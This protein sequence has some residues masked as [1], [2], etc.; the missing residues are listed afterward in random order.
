M[1]CCSIK[2]TAIHHK[3]A[4]TP[5]AITVSSRC[6]MY[7]PVFSCLRFFASTTWYTLRTP[8]H[9]PRKS[10]VWKQSTSQA[11]CPIGEQ[12]SRLRGT[13]RPCTIKSGLWAIGCQFSVL[14]ERQPSAVRLHPKAGRT[15]SLV[16]YVPPQL[17]QV[18]GAIRL[19]CSWS[20]FL[21]QY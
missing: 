19:N 15:R 3:I 11:S 2:L 6:Q 7:T 4:V 20:E 21:Y 8:P 17:R 16:F 13:N 14:E 9:T 12:R 18:V 5:D 1:H 10:R